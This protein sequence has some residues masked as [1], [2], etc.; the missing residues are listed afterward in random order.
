MFE[1]LLL[2]A[3]L[4]AEVPDAG[5]LLR[6]AD[7]PRRAL[8]HSVVRLR[9]TVQPDDGPAQTGEFDLY[10]GD[11]NEQLVV[12]RDKKNKGR[13]FL[14]RG[15]KSWLIVPGSKN[16]IA[17][18]ANQRMLGASSF[19]DLARVRH[20]EDYTGSLR[21]G[22]EACGQPAQPCQVAEIT[23]TAKSAPYA[24][25]TLWIDAAGLLQKAVYRLASGK[26]AKEIVYRYRD[27]NGRTL[28]AGLTL[29]DLLLPGNTGKTTL[30]YLDYRTTEHPAD[31]FNPESHVKR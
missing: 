30:E 28:P 5:A 25:G 19:A 27:D 15:D 21:P 24:S 3:A 16:P 13:K 12:F 2:A 18:T 4:A 26:A 7:A 20:A 8:L 14:L 29:Q 31:W 23:A 22:L 9:A 1:T 10:L 11:E 17:I 6:S